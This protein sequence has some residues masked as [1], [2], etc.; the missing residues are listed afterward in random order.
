MIQVY[1][2]GMWQA[3]GAFLE[4]VEE[5]ALDCC[6]K[7]AAHSRTQATADVGALQCGEILQSKRQAAPGR[8]TRRSA[9]LS[10]WRI[11][12]HRASAVTSRRCT[13]VVL[14][15]VARHVQRL[16]LDAATAGVPLQNCVLF[17]SMLCAPAA[18]NSAST[19]LTH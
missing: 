2:L 9:S 13:C 8:P 11:A 16:C 1:S 12:A 14:K 3:L 7:Q 6:F 18:V 10:R 5:T 19:T 17:V 4:H 15:L